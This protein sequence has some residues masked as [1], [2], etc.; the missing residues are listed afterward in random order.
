MFSPVIMALVALY[1]ILGFVVVRRFRKPTCRV[2][3]YREFCPSR[4]SEYAESSGKQC[5]SCGQTVRCSAST[6]VPKV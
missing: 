1:I 4:E 6:D 2:C 3:L 5:W